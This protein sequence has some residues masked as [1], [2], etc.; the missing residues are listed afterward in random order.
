MSLSSIAVKLEDD[1]KRRI[2]NLGEIKER[3]SH[4]LM[5]RA[6]LDY[7]EKEERIEKEKQEDKQRWEHYSQTGEAIKHDDM[8]D[9]LKS[10]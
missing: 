10:L 5:K 2:Q 1:V 8:K 4:W 9:W 3:S 6:I 7:L